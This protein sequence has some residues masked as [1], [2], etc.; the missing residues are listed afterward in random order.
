MKKIGIASFIWLILLIIFF[1]PIFFEGKSLAP[2]D[3]LSSLIEPFANQDKSLIKST[4]TI[5]AILQYLPYHWAVAKSLIED[6][7]IGW[8]PYCSGGMS[9]VENTM[10]CPGD[11]HHYL[12]CFLPTWVS[13]N[14]GILMQFFLAGL[15]MLVLLKNRKIWGP[16]AFVGAISFGF[17][18]QFILWIYHRWVLGAMCWAPWIVWAFLVAR[19]KGRVLDL[20][21]IVFI[22]LAFRG[23]HLQACVF[24]VLL[25]IIVWIADWWTSKD[26]K[27]IVNLWKSSWLYLISGI[28]GALLSMDVFIET[29]PAYLRGGAPRGEF[30]FLEALSTIPMYVTSLIPTIFGT[31]Y[32]M[33]LRI[34]YWYLFDIKYFG[35]VSL[36]LAFLACFNKKAPKVAKFLFIGGVI[37]CF[38]PLQAWIYSRYTCVF[39]LGGAWLAAWQLMELPRESKRRVWNKLLYVFGACVLLWILGSCLLSVY[40]NE[41]YVEAQHFVSRFAQY[42]QYQ[43]WYDLRIDRLLNDCFVWAPRNILL[44]SL[45]GIGLWICSKIHEGAS[46]LTGKSCL[47]A[48]CVFIECFVLGQVWIS[49]SDK[50]KGVENQLYETPEWMVS[51]QQEMKQGGSLIGSVAK[52]HSWMSNISSA[53]GIR[54]IWSYET[55]APRSIWSGNCVNAQGAAKMGISHW[56][57][58]PEISE[59][60]GEGWVFLYKNSHFSLYKNSYFHGLYIAGLALGDRQ[61]IEPL[62][63]TVNRRCLQLPPHT[64]NLEVLET[65]SEG[66]RYRINNGE[67]KYPHPTEVFGIGIDFD[68][69]IGDEGAQLMLQYIPPYRT[70]Y[71]WGISITLAGL[72]AYSGLRRIRQKRL[73]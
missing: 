21:S 33:D 34:D 30:S 66:W 64:K 54:Q 3:I 51:L 43:D 18:S 9:L 6:G 16:A 42:G 28:F 12:S 37:F 50:P 31:P 71:F 40:F 62:W 20:L 5:D 68:Q 35:G 52:P 8:N 32:T 23:G 47:V 36:I 45:M 17:Y 22:A 56:L 24:V 29:I 63:K 48:M 15:G 10:L 26:R 44:L 69:A 39:A 2:L 57:I 59:K 70:L 1:Y 7:Y 19:Q 61:N 25:T 73:M 58:A 27:N 55:V 53:Y 49:Y 65:Y 60:P 67:W 13:W 4:Y 38:T 11:W 46:G 41:F 72:I 14:L